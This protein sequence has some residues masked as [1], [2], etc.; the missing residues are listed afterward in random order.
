[1]FSLNISFRFVAHPKPT[2]R[3]SV[4]CL[5]LSDLR[6]LLLPI[7]SISI[8]S[9]HEHEHPYRYTSDRWLWDEETQ[10]RKRYKRFNVPE[11]KRIAANSVR[12]NNCSSITKLTDGNSN[13]IFR[14][15]MDDGRAVIARI[16][17][18]VLD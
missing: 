6:Y 17:V 5:S 4:R 8:S 7:R 9:D 14:L 3:A 18:T 10:L 16:P 12:A 13:K 1:M 11:L 2:L 15:V